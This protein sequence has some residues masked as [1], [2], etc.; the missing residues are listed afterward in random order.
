[1]KTEM[2]GPQDLQP[3]L[4]GLVER[5]AQERVDPHRNRQGSVQMRTFKPTND[6]ADCWSVAHSHNY[7]IKVK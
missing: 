5:Y 1:M 3:S 7:I 6:S 2:F 4:Q